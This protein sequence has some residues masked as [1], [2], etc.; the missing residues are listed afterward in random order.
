MKILLTTFLL[1]IISLSLRAEKKIDITPIKLPYDSLIL[2]DIYASKSN[3]LVRSENTIYR[4]SDN[5]D[6]WNIVFESTKKISQLY[7]LDSLTAFIVGDSGMVYRTYDFGESWVNFTSNED[8][9]FKGIAAKDSANYMIISEFRAYI[10]KKDSTNLIPLA[11]VSDI[12]LY[13]IIYSS[14]KYYFHGLKKKETNTDEMGNE[15]VILFLPYNVFDGEKLEQYNSLEIQAIADHPYTTT[16]SLRL[17]SSNYGVYHSAVNKYSKDAGINLN[18]GINSIFYFDVVAILFQNDNI[19]HVDE[20]QG[21]TSFFSREGIWVTTSLESLLNPKFDGQ[22]LN[23]YNKLEHQNLNIKPINSVSRKDSN[24]FYIASNNSTIYR[25]DFTDVIT[26]VE[27]DKSVP[28]R[29]HGN[30]LS[31]DDKVDI[32]SIYNYMGI[33]VNYTPITD[34]MYRIPKGLN[35]ITYST[36]SVVSTMKV[37]VVKE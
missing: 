10:H 30:I 18:R 17:F 27:I 6:N 16:D 3:I 23:Y 37:L 5:G 13:N 7:A 34:T 24:S 21:N 31:F 20:Y 9:N 25:A 11:Y 8:Q 1:F 2:K 29:V 28:I 35:F 36:N 22:S 12:P 15:N 4:S 19:I 14:N 26:S 32:L 33:P